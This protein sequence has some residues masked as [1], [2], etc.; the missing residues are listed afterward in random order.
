MGLGSL[1][2]LRN[3]KQLTLAERMKEDPNIWFYRPMQEEL[4]TYAAQDVMYLPLLYQR[5]CDELRDPA[6]VRVLS[7]SRSYSSYARMNLALSS[8]KAAE[9]RGL[10]LQAMLATQTD[11]AL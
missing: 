8:P 9:K 11:A 6:G 5:L 2:Q 4:I 3:E 7:R 10:R 1:L